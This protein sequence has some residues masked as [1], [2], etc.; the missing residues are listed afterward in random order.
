MARKCG[1]WQCRLCL[2]PF[3]RQRN[4]RAAV[5]V[6]GGKTWRGQGIVHK[7]SAGNAGM[8]GKK[9]KRFPVKRCAAA[10]AE[11]PIVARIALFRVNACLA[12]FG[13]Y[14]VISEVRAPSE[15]AAGAPFAT[16][17]VADGIQHRLAVHRDGTGAAAASGGSP[18]PIALFRFSSTLSR[19]PSVVSHF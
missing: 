12:G 5:F 9:P 1:P 17:A 4:P 14:V 19:K 8:I 16:G 15:G 7:A 10:R 13:G 18:H 2:Q 11:I 6:L 3:L